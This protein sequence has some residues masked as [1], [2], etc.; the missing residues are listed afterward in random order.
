[1]AISINLK[2]NSFDYNKMVKQNLADLVFEN[3]DS[4]S[5][6]LDM[7]TELHTLTGVDLLK[8]FGDWTANELRNFS[9][10]LSAFVDALKD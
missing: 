2:N 9:E 10:I 4:T 7:L 8:P 3:A 6:A 5:D 1:M